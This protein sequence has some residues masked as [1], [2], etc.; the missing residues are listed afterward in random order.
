MIKPGDRVTLFSDMRRNATVVELKRK[1]SNSWFV[2]GT[3]DLKIEAKVEFDDGEVAVFPMNQ[4]MPL[5]E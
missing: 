4:L 3:S 1:K 5:H 2:G